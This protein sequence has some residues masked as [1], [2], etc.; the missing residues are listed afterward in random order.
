MTSSQ[1]VLFVFGLGY[2]AMQLALR[3]RSRGWQIA[4]TVR[5]ADKAA[6]LRQQGLGA[7]A[8]PGGPEIAIPEGAHWLITLPPTDEGCPAAAAFGGCALQA[9]SVTYLSTT[10]V[11]GDLA[12]GWAFEWSPVAPATLRATARV[13]AERQWLEA[14]NGAARIVRLPGIYG[15]GR[16]P[17]ERLRAGT[18]ERIVKPGQVFSRIH[19]EDIASGLEA[20]L[21]RPGARGVFHL[22]DDEPAPPQD[23]TAFAAQLIGLPPP[24]EVA[25][26]AARLSDMAASF[27]AECKRVSNAR[28]KA[29]LAW[30]PAYPTYREGLAATL[31]VEAQKRPY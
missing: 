15:P 24:P 21:Q 12:C 10:G 30:R 18:A 8:W 28:A 11:Y 9:A 22:C 1:L 4:G 17:F 26:D 23:V 20:L 6:R 27:Y 3:L 7:I 2:S 13:K 16:S 19:V 25:F 14:T 31:S 5:S 29:A